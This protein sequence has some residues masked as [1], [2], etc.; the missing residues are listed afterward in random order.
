MYI[1][2]IWLYYIYKLSVIYR[3]YMYRFYIYK[4]W[5]RGK[6]I[7]GHTYT[8]VYMHTTEI[9][10]LKH[11]KIKM[12]KNTYKFHLLNCPYQ[13]ST[14]LQIPHVNYFLYIS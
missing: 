6:E 12:K 3:L 4:E 13:K 2:N 14:N 5:Q 11:L 10:N 8:Y 7:D 9:E 1:F